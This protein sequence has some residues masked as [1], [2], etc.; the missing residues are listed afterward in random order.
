GDTFLPHYWSR[1][2]EPLRFGHS[3]GCF[4]DL[5][6]HLAAHPVRQDATPLEWALH[7]DSPAAR[8][9]VNHVQVRPGLGLMAMNL[10][11]SQ[12][13]SVD[14]VHEPTALEIGFHRANSLEITHENGTDLGVHS[15]QFY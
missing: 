8:G 7:W 3:L 13:W 1:L 5:S 4:Q 15:D 9:S 12:A 6:Q 14:V 10:V 2:M 11:Q